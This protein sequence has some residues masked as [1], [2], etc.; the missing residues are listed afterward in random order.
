M[1]RQ[2]DL[3]LIRGDSISHVRMDTM[4]K[5]TMDHYFMLLKDTLDE[6]NV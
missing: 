3:S 1:K 2:K 6:H 4:N 5:E